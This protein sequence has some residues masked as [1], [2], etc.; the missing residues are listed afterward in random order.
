MIHSTRFRHRAATCALLLA[1][2][3]LLAQAIERLPVD[4]A[5]RATI[6]DLQLVYEDGLLDLSWPD[7]GPCWSLA[8][9]Q[10]AWSGFVIID[11]PA[12]TLE[13]GRLHVSLPADGELG[14]FRVYTS[15]KP[16]A[17]V[18]QNPLQSF[19][20]ESVTLDASPSSDPDGDSLSVH[21]SVPGFGEFDQLAVQLD[22]P[23][24]PDS[25]V[26]T[27]IVSDPCGEADTLLVALGW[28]WNVDRAWH[29]AP[30]GSDA[31]D[32]SP[33]SPLE[34]L[35]HAMDMVQ[36]TPER[37]LI[38]V[39][40]GNYAQAA[41]LRSDLLVRGGFDEDF[42]ECDPQTVTQFSNPAG[43]SALQGIQVVQCQLY[44][45][46]FN[47]TNHTG[48]GGSCYG[49]FL[50][51]LDGVTFDNCSFRTGPAGGGVP[52]AAGANGPSIFDAGNS[53]VPGCE[54]DGIFC[55]NCNRPSGGLG[56]TATGVYS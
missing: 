50:R 31:N 7:S 34:T 13:D 36:F 45:L 3:P 12:T 10:D 19:G 6:S 27:L 14:F 17:A 56:G 41:D 25:L 23:E 48:S 24:L 29:V 26:A 55:D 2:A 43:N 5:D 47:G 9:S 15:A 18:V 1:I 54:D 32:G 42:S 37:N 28:S 33:G 8:T 52:G 4:E 51:N 35:Q 53:G 39:Q 20:L 38:Y 11:D 30:G 46:T 21:W 22:L 49:A 44:N 40:R 16:V